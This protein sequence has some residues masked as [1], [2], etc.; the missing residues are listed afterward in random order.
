MPLPTNN[1]PPPTNSNTVAVPPANTPN[2]GDIL[3]FTPHNFHQPITVHFPPQRLPVCEK[4]KRNYKARDICRVKW[5]H[6]GLPWTTAYVCITIDE[7]CIGADGKYIAGQILTAMTVTVQQ[8]Q[9]CPYFV[10]K[11]FMDFKMPCCANCKKANRTRNFCREVHGHRDLPWTTVYVV[12][13]ATEKGGELRD[14]SGGEKEKETGSDDGDDIH[15]IAPSRTFLSM[16]STKQNSIQW[17]ERGTVNGKVFAPMAEGSFSPKTN[18][19]AMAMQQ[20]SSA[21]WQANYNQYHMNQML[22]PSQTIKV[23]QTP[24]TGKKRQIKAHE[25]ADINNAA[26]ENQQQNR[27]KE[28]KAAIANANLQSRAEVNAQFTRQQFCNSQLYMQQM[29]Q[30]Q[31]WQMQQA[32]QIQHQQQQEDGEKQSQPPKKR[33]RK[34]DGQKEEDVKSSDSVDGSIFYDEAKE[35]EKLPLAENPEEDGELLDWFDSSFDVK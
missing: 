9:P 23:T 12:L 10:K 19:A 13:S 6:A 25:S 35:A 32:R 2:K 22:L 1:N 14:D 18:V 29:M 21:T 33:G 3:R 28:A 27:S 17:L 8:Q 15:N 5:G 7:S 24:K 31:V 16:V 4:C 11:Q 20:Q 26:P 34:K 30:M